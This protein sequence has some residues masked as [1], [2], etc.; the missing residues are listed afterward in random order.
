MSRTIGW[1]LFFAMAAVPVAAQTTKTVCKTN[2][3]GNV[4]CESR[5]QPPP[6]PRPTI[7]GGLTSALLSYEEGRQEALQRQQQFAASAAARYAESRRD[8]LALSLFLPRAKMVL[9]EAVDTL[10]LSGA[11][12]DSFWKQSAGT[13]GALFQVNPEVS[14]SVMRE[15]IEPLVKEYSRSDAGFWTRAAAAFIA[16]AD[17]VNL[18]DAQRLSAWKESA[19]PVL[20][21]VRNTSLETDEAAMRAVLAPV[22]ARYVMFH[23]LPSPPVSMPLEKTPRRRAVVKKPA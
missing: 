11:V 12:A 20:H 9:Q 17:S 14:T 7:A 6:R 10:L 5:T 18:V 21:P 8:S 1:L 13:L 23:P 4:E 3:F 2:A 19:W 22:L 16:V 15:A